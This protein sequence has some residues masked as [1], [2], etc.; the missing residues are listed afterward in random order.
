MTETST[1]RQASLVLTHA[2]DKLQRAQ[3][4]H[5]LTIDPEAREDTVRERCQVNAAAEAMRACLRDY[6]I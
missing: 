3:A 4:K 5:I 2:I 6:R 1:L